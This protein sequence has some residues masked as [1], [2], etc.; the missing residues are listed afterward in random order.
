MNFSLDVRRCTPERNV[1]WKGVKCIVGCESQT[2]QTTQLSEDMFK[3]F[4]NLARTEKKE[5]EWDEEERCKG[6]V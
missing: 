2:M 5:H 4:I 6:R 3:Q 1:L